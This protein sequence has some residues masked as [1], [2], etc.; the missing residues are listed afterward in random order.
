MT[1]GRDQKPRPDQLCLEEE[2]PV[3]AS[4]SAHVTGARSR[5]S[6]YRVTRAGEPT[7]QTARR[8]DEV[9]VLL[10]LQP[11]DFWLRMRRA[12]QLVSLENPQRYKSTIYW[13]KSIMFFM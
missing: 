3:T 9:S 7:L 10:R 13:C 4:V 1:E 12:V 8:Q 2:R 11:V 6:L 5:G